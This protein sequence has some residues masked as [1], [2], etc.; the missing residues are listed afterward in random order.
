MKKEY[1]RFKSSF[2]NKMLLMKKTDSSMSDSNKD[3]HPCLEWEEKVTF[4]SATLLPD[5]QLLSTR[6]REIGVTYFCWCKENLFV[7]QMGLSFLR[8]LN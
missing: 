5:R 3:S 7:G 1:S 8:E 4:S 6:S 2:G